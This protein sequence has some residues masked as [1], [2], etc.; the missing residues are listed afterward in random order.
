VGRYIN[1]AQLIEEGKETYY[2]EV[3]LKSSHGCHEAKHDLKPW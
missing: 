2:Y 1:L 3:I